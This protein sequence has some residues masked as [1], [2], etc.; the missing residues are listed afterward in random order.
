MTGSDTSTNSSNT[1]QE[2]RDAVETSQPGPA[3]NQT[4]VTA[5]TTTM[6]DP[7]TGAVETYTVESHK[8]VVVESSKEVIEPSKDAVESSKNEVESIHVADK[9]SKLDDEKEDGKKKKKKTK[10]KKDPAVPIHQLFRFAS[11][12]ELLMIFIAMVLSLA[13][14]ALHPAVIVIFGEFLGTAGA[15]FMGVGKLTDATHDVILI[16]VYIGTATF[17]AAYISQAFWIMTAE[18]QTRRIRQAYVHAILRQDL[19]WF[20]KADEGSLTTRLAADTQLIQDGISEKFGLFLMSIGSFVS[21]FVIAFVKGWRLAVIILATLPV[22]A[23]AGAVLG[24]SITK[25]TLNVQD[26]YAEAGAVAEQVFSGLRTV[27]SFSLQNRFAGLYEK[28]LVKARK[29]GIRRGLFLGVGFGIFLFVLF[30]TYALSFWY[31]GKLVR[32]HQMDGATVLVVFFAMIIGAMTLMQLPPNLSA[33]STA[34]GAAYKIYATID[35][36]PEIDVDN[37]SGLKPK[38]VTGEIEFRNVKFSYPTRPDIPILKNLSIKIKPGTTV[39]FVGPSGSGKSTSVNLIQ[40]FYDPKDGEVLLD[41]VGLKYLNVKWLRSHIGVVSQEPVLFNM[42]IRQNL[43]MGIDYEASREEIIEACKKA[44]C[45]TFI[46]QLPDGYDTLVGEHGGMLSGGQ[47]QRI[48]IARAILKNPTIL[49]LDEATSAL[50]TQSERLVQRALDAASANRTTIVIAHRLSTIRNADHI[51]VMHEGELIEQGTHDELLSRNGVYSELVHKQKIAT[52]K[53]GADEDEVFDEE[54]IL[55]KETEE[56]LLQQKKIDELAELERDS[57]SDHLVRMSTISS[58]DAFELKLKREK[59][60]R[61]NRMKQKAPIGEI[62]QQMR[63]EWKYLATG[64]GGAAIAG[65]I[66]PCFALIFS[67]IIAV[68]ILSPSTSAPGPLEGTNLYAFIF[69]MFGIASFLGFGIQIIS[70]EIAGELYTE[71]LRSMIFRAYMRQEVGF[72]DDEENSMGALTS[73]LA[74]DAKNVNEL[75]TKV[76]GDIA[77]L[78]S[79]TIA[80]LVIAFVQSWILTLIVLCMAPFI[81]AATFYEAR[82]RR[83][84]E[85]ETAKAHEQSGEVAGEAIKEIRTVASLNK[86]DHFELRFDRALE[87][88][89][90]LAK[91]KAYLSSIGYAL[92]Q[93]INM[94]TN[95]VAFYA[96]AR[97]IDDKKL[98]FEQMLIAMMAVMITAQGVGRTSTFTATYAKAKNSAIAAFEVLH[99]KS[100][101]DPDLEGIEPESSTIRGDLSFK[102]IVFRYPARPN[103]PIFDGEFNLEGKAGQTIALVGPSGC[104]KSTTIGMLQ[105]W[106]DPIDGTVRL[107]DYDTKNF[108]LGNLRSHMALVGQEP[109]LFDMSIGDNIRFGALEDNQASVTMEQVTEACKAANIHQFVSE[110][111]NGYDTRVGDKGSQLSGGQKQRIAIARALIRNP[112]VLLLDEATSALDS[113][114]EKLVQAAIDNIISVGG[115]TTITIAHRLSTIQDADCI[116]VVMNGKIVECGTHWELLELDG[117]YA[118]LVRQQSL[119]ADH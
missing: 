109:V 104:G 29:A 11:K 79:T 45:H 18:N 85:D 10:K 55:R 49:L 6:R 30:C 72:F 48:A 98:N 105:R 15:A 87:R 25:F 101:I 68:L 110:L 94:Y 99:R 32:G 65:A 102:D 22:L 107:D 76:W 90:I 115:R 3:A 70:F 58:I 52:K 24:W 12:L 56:L 41:G 33:V 117:Q 111:P 89:H 73:K 106:Y 97:L 2:L 46:S 71:R 38:E 93:A 66:F 59:E 1:V 91:R 86:Q 118:S 13:V 54:E 119:N 69:V 9:P 57:K 100:S 108:T 14:G 40:R 95:A 61:K 39:A 4:I 47:K 63:P 31:G 80:G 35:R 60:N 37:T 50:D 64:V 112:R 84:F 88:P 62:L 116:C 7:V 114:S 23:C 83:G 67:K 81:A 77:Q 27:Y 36:V 19:G 53:T 92:H 75:V 78:C 34:A 20:D 96:G 74:I 17:V 21:G 16:F 5:T 51:V 103:I 43:L 26:G 42:T 8:E 44:N 113:E 28:K 82:I